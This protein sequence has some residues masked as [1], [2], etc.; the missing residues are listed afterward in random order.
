[1]N[2]TNNTIRTFNNHQT[3]TSGRVMNIKPTKSNQQ[4][5]IILQQIILTVHPVPF[6]F[7]DSPHEIEVK[8]GRRVVITM[9]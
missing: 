1:V 6:L 2:S 3:W 7:G 8:T 4:Y 9:R 5:Y